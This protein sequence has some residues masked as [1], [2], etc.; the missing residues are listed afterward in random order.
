VSFSGYTFGGVTAEEIRERL[1]WD[2]P[3]LAANALHIVDKRK[4]TVLLEPRPPQL[5][6][7]VALERQRAEGRPMRAIVLKARQLG[8]STWVQ[9]K[10]IQRASQ[11]ENQNALVVA[12]RADSAGEL[13]KIGRT[14]YVKLPP[15]IKPPLAGFSDSARSTK[16]LRFGNR[17]RQHLEAGDL[18]INSEYTVDTAQE[19]EAGRGFT[20]SVVHLS[21]VAFWPDESKLTAIL[22]A[23][24]YEPE[25]MVVLESTAN[26]SNFFKRRWDEAVAGEEAP[27]GSSY[28]PIFA[29]W[30]EDPAYTLPFRDDEHEHR[31]REE[32]YGRGEWGEDEPMY[33]DQFGLTMEQL[34]WRRMMIRDQ[35][36]S[37]LDKW[38]QEYPASPGEA[39]MASS[40]HVF[41]MR[42]VSHVVDR[43]AKTDPQVPTETEPGPARG[44]LHGMDF[45]TKPTLT[46]TIEVP[47]TA[48]WTPK[49]ATAFPDRHPWWRVWERPLT[50]KAL[51][52]LPMDERQGKKASAHVVAVDAA[53]GRETDEGDLDYMAIQ[54]LNHRTFGQCAEWRAR[55]D[56]DKVA[57]E[58]LLAALHWNGAWIGVETT[59]GHGTPIVKRLVEKYRYPRVYLRRS[60]ESKKVKTQDR[61]GW[62]TN[63]RTK[64]ILIA[65]ASELLRGAAEDLD[66]IRSRF[67][68]QELTTYVYVETASGNKRAEAEST[69]HDDLLMCW[70]IG[71]Q[72]CQ[73]LPL[74][75]QGGRG[76]VNTGR[77]VKSKSSGY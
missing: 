11:H 2:T 13:F 17:A 69:A 48:V 62:D 50:Q 28:V 39:F 3:Y 46:G 53:E 52:Q 32:V 77:P 45:K 55:M 43:T 42:M 22:N 67:L 70:M 63:V 61:L 72:L 12:H 76:P 35:C 29:A 60:E 64:K 14:M 51:E 9:G 16:Y 56:P 4:R 33:V 26:G 34:H 73:E 41:S 59:G 1:R 40:K 21:E 65:L 24:P 27:D 23:V 10:L 38:K 19:F 36:E 18:G 66:G 74:P 49:E 47:Q 8:F 31:F 6:L 57:L 15:E 37:K 25:T 44:L 58:A 75:M 68:A 20:Y 5:R 7:D 30:H 54:V 71:Q